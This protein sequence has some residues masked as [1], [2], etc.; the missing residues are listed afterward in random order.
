MLV[1]VGVE[2]SALVGSPKQCHNVWHDC[3]GRQWSDDMIQILRWSPRCHPSLSRGREMLM[4]R[5]LMRGRR[6]KLDQENTS[7]LLTGCPPKLCMVSAMSKVLC[8][9]NI[10]VM[11]PL[12]NCRQSAW[13]WIHDWS[14]QSPHIPTGRLSPKLSRVEFRW[15]IITLNLW[16]PGSFSYEKTRRL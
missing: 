13:L 2:L 6:S 12:R 15:V 10:L 14:I 1:E 3:C 8:I 16:S 7:F 4:S 11:T 5:R 9:F